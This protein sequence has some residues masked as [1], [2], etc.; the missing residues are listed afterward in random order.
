MTA[1]VQTG[2]DFDA[3]GRI[4]AVGDVPIEP[5]ASKRVSVKSCRS[6]LRAIRS[7]AERGGICWASAETIA[8]DVDA[9]ERTVR[10]AIDHLATIGFIRVATRT[11]STSRITIDWGRIAEVIAMRNSGWTPPRPRSTAPQTPPPMS[12]P[13]SAPGPTTDG[14]ADRSV[15]FRTPDN[16]ARTP[17]SL[18]PTPDSLSGDPG[19]SVRGPRTVCPTTTFTTPNPPS[20]SLTDR[21]VRPSHGGHD[22]THVQSELV[23]AGV[24]EWRSAMDFMRGSV[25]AAHAAAILATHVARPG[26]YGPTAVFLRCKNAHPDVAPTDGWPPPMPDST[27]AR[28]CTRADRHRRQVRDEASRRSDVSRAACLAV[29]HDR[30]VREGLS[31]HVTADERNAAESFAARRRAQPA[32]M[33]A[34]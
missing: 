16:L 31:D 3:A 26:A 7:F 20:P 32:A 19:Q 34:A 2:F 14:T 5:D 21:D 12:S 28:D 29:T 10:R 6:V 18:S 33:G 25:T 23:R 4:A 27:Y 13:M 9:S 15:D 24:R 22:W 1:A 30:L 11:G 8:T 17:D